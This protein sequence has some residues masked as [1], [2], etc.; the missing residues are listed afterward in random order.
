MKIKASTLKFTAKLI[1][2]ERISMLKFVR[3]KFVI[4]TF[5]HFSL[6]ISKNKDNHAS[7]RILFF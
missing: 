3:K 4:N 6:N 1:K 2:L 7:G 5:E